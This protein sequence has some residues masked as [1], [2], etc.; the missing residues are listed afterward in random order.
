[1]ASRTFDV[2]VTGLDEL[3]AK[4]SQGRIFGPVKQ[5]I[6]KRG[7]DEGRETAEKESKG[8]YGKKG[9]RLLTTFEQNGLIARVQPRPQARGIAWVVETGRKPGKAPPLRALK[10]WAAEWMD[11]SDKGAL[12]ALQQRIREGGT[13]G[14]GYFAKGEQAADRAIKSGTPKAEREIEAHW[15]R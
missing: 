1:M 8:R 12:R 13:K 15:N 11:V 6:I 3:K 2:T 5:E 9:F 10:P 7:A 14:V 4:L